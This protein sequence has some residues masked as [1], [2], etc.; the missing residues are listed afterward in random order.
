MKPLIIGIAGGTGSGKT[1]VA[2]AIAK[3]LND[4]GVAIIQHD[5][6]YRDRSDLPF[7]E[8][9]KINFDHPD[10][11]ET[12]LFVQHLRELIAGREIRIPVYDF[13]THTRKKGGLLIASQKAIIIEGI[14]IFAEKELR[15]LMDVKI[16]VD[17][18]DD[19]RFI[20]RFQRD[21]NER[22]RNT[23]TVIRQYLETVRPMHIEFAEPS[24]KYADIIIPEGHNPI[25]IDMVVSMIQR[26]QGH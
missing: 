5:S 9:E 15:D 26:I 10:A 7:A 6:Y 4:D 20:R 18:D 3:S 17:T 19:I 25:A 13:T 8:R 11:L 14:L 21:I 22:G 24:R 1:T 2:Q 12:N 23:E 16:F